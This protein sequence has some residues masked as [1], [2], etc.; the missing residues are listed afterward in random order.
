ML[1]D[2]ANFTGRE[3]NSGPK[4][5]VDANNRFDEKWLTLSQG[6]KYK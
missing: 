6:A 5:V 2:E 1:P 4:K 3:D